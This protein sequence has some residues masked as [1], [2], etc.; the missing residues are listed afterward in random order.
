[1]TH[2]VVISRQLILSWGVYPFEVPTDSLPHDFGDV[3]LSVIRS[4]QLGEVGK[5]A[6]LVWGATIGVMGTTDTIRASTI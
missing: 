3:M 6:V 5:T 4:K 1:M 2:D